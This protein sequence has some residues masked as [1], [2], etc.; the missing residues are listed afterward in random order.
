MLANELI[1]RGLRLINEPGRGATLDPDDQADA[2]TALI[3]I[4]DSES[5]SKHFVPGIS[6]HFFPMISGQAIYSYGAGAGLNLRADDFGSL[7]N[8]IPDPCPVKIEDAYIREGSTIVDNEIVDEFRFEAVGSWVLDADPTVEIINNQFKAEQP[9]AATSSTQALTNGPTALVAGRN[10]VLRVDAEVFAG[11]LDIELRD[12]AVAFTTFTIDASGFFELRFTWP[13]TVLPDLN[14]VTALTTDDVRLNSL[15][16]IEDTKRDRLELPDSQ[17]SD[18]SI[19]IVDQTRYNR[20][21]T[22]GTGG[23]PYEILFV[24]GPSEFGEIRFDNSAITG[25]ILVMDVLVNRTKIRSLED[26]IRLNPEAIK[27]I[28]YALADHLA[29]E[30]GKELTLRQ[31]R[32]MDSAWDKLAASN[33]RINMLG[34]DRALRDRPTFDINRGDP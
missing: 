25:D 21:F 15:S 8:G 29:P 20:R 5:V 13:T 11:T 24:R 16:I 30:Y 23:R 2:L 14:L 1:S 22:K 31:V 34:V 17:G 6:R 12:S 3:E 9:A 27:W 4:L 18:Y 32:I 7:V 10:Y 26:E 28:R 19:T 33:R